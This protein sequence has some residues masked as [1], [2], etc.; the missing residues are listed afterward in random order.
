MSTALST[1]LPLMYIP[2]CPEPLRLQ[3]LR[4]ACRQFCRDTEWWREEVTA[5]WLGANG[6]VSIEVS[7]SS[8]TEANGTYAQQSELLSGNIYYLKTGTGYHIVGNS[9]DGYALLNGISPNPSATYFNGTSADTPWLSTWSDA[10][11]GYTVPTFALIQNYLTDDYPNTQIIRTQWVKVDDSVQ[12]ECKW[13]VDNDGVLTFDPALPATADVIKTKIILMPTITAAS[14]DS[15]LVSR[16]GE[17]IAAGAEFNLKVHMGSEQD[18][19]PWY[20]PKGAALARERYL[21]GVGEAKMEVYSEMQSGNKQLDL[22][23]RGW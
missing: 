21:D 6:L 14:V 1:L 11:G 2:K 23:V 16:F 13:S 19:T 3:A 12:N 10:G 15:H 4:N 7:G 22:N 20:D 9:S 8:F 5:D 18:P 17:A